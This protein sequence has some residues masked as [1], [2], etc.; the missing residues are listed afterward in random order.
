MIAYALDASGFLTHKSS[1]G[2]DLSLLLS[3]V[4]IVLLTAGVVM[5]RRR[6]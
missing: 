5:A 6:C 1:V 4:V 2:A 3:A